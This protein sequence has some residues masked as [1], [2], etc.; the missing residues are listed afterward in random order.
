MRK[1]STRI[2]AAKAKLAIELLL[3][4]V[5][6]VSP[7]LVSDHGAQLRKERQVFAHTAQGRSGQA[8]A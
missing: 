2:Q 6:E 5:Y 8:L 3:H 4:A 1:P 7:N